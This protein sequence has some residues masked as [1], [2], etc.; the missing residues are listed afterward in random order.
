M[1]P[2]RTES[3]RDVLLRANTISSSPSN[4]INANTAKK[5]QSVSA[6]S[7]GL[8]FAGVTWK[9]VKTANYD[10][11]ILQK[12]RGQYFPAK[13]ALAL[14]MAKVLMGLLFIAFGVLAIFEKA[15]YSQL[16]SGLWGGAM[17]IV[18]GFLGLVAGKNHRSMVYIVSFLITSLLELAIV[19]LVLVFT[20]TGLIKDYNTPMGFFI[21]KEDNGKPVEFLGKIPLRQRAVIVNAVLVALATLEIFLALAS[22]AIC[23]RETCHCS[24]M[25]STLIGSRANLLEIDTSPE[26]RAKA[27]RLATWIRQQTFYQNHPNVKAVPQVHTIFGPAMNY[28][29]RTPSTYTVAPSSLPPSYFTNFVP[30]RFHQHHGFRSWQ[31]SDMQLPPVDYDITSLKGRNQ[32]VKKK[33]RRSKRIETP[34]Q[35]D[36]L[37]QTYTGLDRDIA[38]EFIQQTMDPSRSLAIRNIILDRESGISDYEV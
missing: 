12:E 8:N 14:G 28:P 16:G 13:L 2:R 4:S 34:T 1:K 20:T 5:P 19:G 3:M 29:R 31:A 11:E 15:T 26:G 25:N 6:L 17:I 36:T 33:R 10:V 32:K 21:D 30:P 38:E 22:V 24:K 35:S 27:D 37:S 9:S 7:S 18:C 23:A